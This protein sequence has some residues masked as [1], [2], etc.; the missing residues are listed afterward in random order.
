MRL[1]NFSH[2]PSRQT[3]RHGDAHR[4]AGAGLG[5]CR[6]DSVGCFEVRLS[7]PDHYGRATPSASWSDRAARS[8]I[9]ATRVRNCDQLRSA[10]IFLNRSRARK[11]M[12]GDCAVTIP[13]SQ[14]LP[15]LR[16]CAN[17]TRPPPDG[18]PRARCRFFLDSAASRWLTSRSRWRILQPIQ[19]WLV[20]PC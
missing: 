6:E 19:I 13:R 3:M 14:T 7:F 15:Y 9:H 17:T 5:S 10:G 2:A 18:I 8:V 16:N 4:G 20:D 12:L 1:S 11:R